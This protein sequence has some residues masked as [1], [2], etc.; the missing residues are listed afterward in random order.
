MMYEAQRTAESDRDAARDAQELAEIARD[1]ARRAQELA[2]SDRDVAYDAQE[3]AEAARDVARRAQELAESD[4]DVALHDLNVAQ[5]GW[6]EAELRCEA[7]AKE[8]RRNAEAARALVH[9]ALPEQLPAPE[10]VSLAAHYAPATTA[11]IVGGDWYDAMLLDDGRLWCGVGDATGNGLPAAAVM[12]RIANAARVAAI[13]DPDPAA[14]VAVMDQ[15]LRAHDAGG[16]ATATV[17]VYDPERR[18]L[19]WARAGHVPPVIALPHEPAAIVEPS[20]APPLGVVAKLVAGSPPEHELHL[21][22]G[23][24]VALF[25][26]GLVERRGEPIDDGFA[27]VTAALGAADLPDDA[28][29]IAA[30]IIDACVPD[31]TDDDI[32]LLVLATH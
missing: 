17:A 32:C 15:A 29:G 16:L 9:T 8:S 26:D 5:D 19:R 25:T 20:A 24:V 11:G 27:R 3:L 30:R 13:N 1:V 21:P 7:T 4:R 12:G 14:V 31:D 22:P 18:A 6:D 23:S 28:D 10:G 2:E